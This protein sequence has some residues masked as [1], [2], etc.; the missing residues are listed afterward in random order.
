MAVPQVTVPVN[1][2]S[3]PV[4]RVAEPRPQSAPA[5][6][7]IA[8]TP[9][10]LQLFYQGNIASTRLTEFYLRN[11]GRT[12]SIVEFGRDIESFRAFVRIY[13]E[14]FPE[15]KTRVDRALSL[16]GG[17]IR[18]LR[19]FITTYDASTPEQRIELDRLMSIEWWRVTLREEVLRSRFQYEASTQSRREE[20]NE[21]PVAKFYKSIVS[22][23][24]SLFVCARDFLNLITCGAV[25]LC[26]KACT[27]P[28]GWP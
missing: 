1:V 5:P 2:S 4:A 6:I 24:S 25:S 20:L 19:E 11:T 17:D 16:Q 8:A 15:Y 18:N 23:I 28:R 26:R 10:T 22:V 14:G 3:S 13:D 9:N 27:L 12:L 7:G 21:R